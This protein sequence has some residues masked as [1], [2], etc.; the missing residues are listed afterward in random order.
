MD[1][2]FINIW[3]FKE[4]K[5]GLYIKNREVFGKLYERYGCLMD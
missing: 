3:I 1:K 2:L 4:R 5:K